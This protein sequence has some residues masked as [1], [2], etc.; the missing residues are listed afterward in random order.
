MPVLSKRFQV[1]LF[2]ALVSIFLLF[3]GDF[4]ISTL[5][6]F[7]EIKK[8][9]FALLHVNFFDAQ[10]YLMALWRTLSIALIAI[11]LSSIFGLGLGLLFHF[12]IVRISLAF[13]RAIH[14]LFWALIFLQLF[15]LTPLSALLAIILPYSA[16]LAKVYSE[17][18]E[19]HDTFPR[20][21]RGKNISS[22]A[23]FFYTKL[24]DALPHLFSYTLYRFE[25]AIKSTAILGFLGL[26]TLGYY[27]E[28]SF[29]QGYYSEVWLL[30]ILFYLLIASIKYWFTQKI[31]PIVFLVSL[32]SLGNLGEFSLSNIIRFF[33]Q[34]IIPSPIRN[35]KEF[36]ELFIWLQDLFTTQI[37]P[38]VWN[39]I[40]LTQVS[41]LATAFLTLLFVPLIGKHLTKQPT[42]FFGHLWLIIL[43]STPEYILAY[44]FLQIF[45]PSMLPAALALALH[46]GAIIAFIIG[47]ESNTLK[48][49][50]DTRLSP[51][52]KYIYEI[53]PRLYGSFLAFL[54]YR[55]EVIMRESA[56]LG[57]LGIHTLGFF[58]DSAIAEF[59]LD[60]MFLLLLAT[61]FLNILIDQISHRVRRKI[62]LS[63]DLKRAQNCCRV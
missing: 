60:T 29:M 61:A 41:L 17:I 15:G 62:A 36:G 63:K 22:I 25:C 8:F 6:P 32:L 59:K 3:F 57:I 20:E 5:H 7:L 9:F 58:I 34:D 42:H 40:V 13:T 48:L 47:K 49:R 44:L 2:F 46:N 27:L 50:D 16:I 38:G 19:E 39:T 23:L 51:A 14:E 37:L 31:A 28:S 33:T 24:P 52:N 18:L 56:I 35:E 1:S 10:N 54:F 55:W 11:I 30:L 21:L 45:G 43:R 26:P 53:L 12:Q 4:S